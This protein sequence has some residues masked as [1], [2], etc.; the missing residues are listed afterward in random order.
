MPN[1]INQGMARHAPTATPRRGR[2]PV[3]TLNDIFTVP[4]SAGTTTFPVPAA[5]ARSSPTNILTLCRS[6]FVEQESLQLRHTGGT[7][8]HLPCPFR[9]VHIGDDAH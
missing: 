1:P 5:F 7:P 2:P 6:V 9:T 3:A 8:H 4:C